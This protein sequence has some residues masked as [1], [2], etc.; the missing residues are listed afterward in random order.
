MYTSNAETNYN[1]KHLF[2]W[3]SCLSHSNVF[4]RH[5]MVFYEQFD[6]IKLHGRSETSL[7]TSGLPFDICGFMRVIRQKSL[8]KCQTFK[9]FNINICSFSPVFVLI[10][11]VPRE[12]TNILI[13]SPSRFPISIPFTSFCL[14]F[15]IGESPM[16]LQKFRPLRG[17]WDGMSN[18]SDSS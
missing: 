7:K 11:S 1:I 8:T 4:E 2:Q 17:A 5:A 13:D 3:H 14:S 12:N 6:H 15:T 10:Q 16:Q 18:P 9:V